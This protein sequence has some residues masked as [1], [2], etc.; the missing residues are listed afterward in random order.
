M[1]I[2][3]VIY[4]KITKDKYQVTG[5]PDLY[6]DYPYRYFLE[7]KGKRPLAK[8]STEQAE[9]LFALCE[10]K[11]S[12]LTAKQWSITLFKPTKVEKIWQVEGV[13]IYKLSNQKAA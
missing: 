8:D 1:H 13:T 6:D 10:K 7:I 12:P 2:A 3:D 11:C 5:V 9:E 4:P